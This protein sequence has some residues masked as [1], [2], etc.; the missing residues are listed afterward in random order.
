MHI[1]TVFITPKK[2][3]ITK[4]VK[5]INPIEK[6]GLFETIRPP[7][8]VRLTEQQLDILQKLYSVDYDFIVLPEQ[9]K[10]EQSMQ[11]TVE[12][13]VEQEEQQTNSYQEEQTNEEYEQQK[14]DNVTTKKSR[15][16]KQDNDTIDVVDI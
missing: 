3:N 11:E 1:Y 7:A 5:P 13:N 10:Q 9:V 16:R 15:K 2:S 12:T 8:F 4:L 14:D 6:Y